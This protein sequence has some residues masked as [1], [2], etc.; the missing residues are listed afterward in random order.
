MLLSIIIPVYQ[1]ESYLEQCLNSVLSC[2]LTDC[3]ILLSLGDSMDESNQISRRYAEKHQ[4]IHT[5]TQRGKGLSDARNCTMEVAKGDYILFLDSDDY[6]IPE[7]LDFVISHLRAGSFR[8]DVIVADFYRLSRSSGQIE[9]IFQIGKDMP[10]QYGLDF[11]PQ[12]LRKRQCFWN[13][14]RYLYR[15][16]FLEEQGIRFWEDRFSEDVDFTTSVFL[17]KPEVVFCHSPFY[18]YCVERGDSIMGTLTLKRLS[19]TVAVLERSILRMK[20]SDLPYAPR[21]AAQLQFEYVLNMAIPAELP[22]EDR[23]AARRLYQNWKNV[24]AG[25]SDW[26]VRV[27]GKIIGLL[28]LSV[29]S[30]IL[31]QLKMLRRWGR[32]HISRRKAAK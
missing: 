12:M 24:L 18:V 6:I 16:E 9:E 29:S 26:L 11:L 20:E 15:R 14:W 17:A 23:P 10:V 22:A 25:S 5:L 3:E 4:L 31:H 13:V 8:A 30:R 32:H 21:F 19:D 27:A 28:G 2:D 1:V 7:N